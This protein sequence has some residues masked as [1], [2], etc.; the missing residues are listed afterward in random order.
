M[1]AKGIFCIEGQWTSDLRDQCS[2]EPALRLL[3]DSHSPSVPYIHRNTSTIQE[4]EANISRWLKLKSYPILYLAFHGTPEG[5]LIEGMK[6]RSEVVLFDWFEEILKGKCQ[7]KVIYFGSCAT[8]KTHGHR[9][10]RFVKQTRA[11]AVFGY[12]RDVPWVE[13]TIFEVLLLSYLQRWTLKKSGLRAME[14]ALRKMAGSMANELAF[15]MV[16]SV[17]AKK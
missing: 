16:H 9:I 1:A 4:L 6:A 3:K 2:V 13:S 12:R 5:I 15:W 17:S 11:A 8:L 14:R 7:G 10:N